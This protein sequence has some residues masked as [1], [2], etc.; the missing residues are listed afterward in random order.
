MHTEPLCSV[1]LLATNSY[2]SNLGWE[3]G[4]YSKICSRCELF[5]DF[6]SGWMSVKSH[7]GMWKAWT[8]TVPALCLG[9]SWL[10]ACENQK[11][12]ENSWMLTPPRKSLPSSS[13]VQQHTSR[14]W[15]QLGHPGCRCKVNSKP[16]LNRELFE[17]WVFWFCFRLI[18]ICCEILAGWRDYSR[19]SICG[20]NTFR[21]CGH[22]E[23]ANR[24]FADRFVLTL[25]MMPWFICRL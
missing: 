15:G 21:A 11:K 20:S 23:N 1:P 22:Q 4:G 25:T 7:C 13:A 10:C 5:V 17:V 14:C 6:L 8:H 18:F 3:N 9:H 19:L 2:N 24:L 12:W 16:A